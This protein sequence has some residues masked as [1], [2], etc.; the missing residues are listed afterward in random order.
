MDGEWHSGSRLHDYGYDLS[1]R[2]NEVQVADE[3]E[4]ER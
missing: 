4:T 3:V 2:A 1:N